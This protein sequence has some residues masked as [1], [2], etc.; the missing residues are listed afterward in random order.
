[1]ATINAHQPGISDSKNQNAVIRV[2]TYKEKHSHAVPEGNTLHY[3]AG[4]IQLQQNF[5]TFGS[6]TDTP[7]PPEFSWEKRGQSRKQQKKA[8]YQT[9]L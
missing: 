2:Y 6:L 1:M 4:N 3:L 5:G 8:M 7:P 9:H